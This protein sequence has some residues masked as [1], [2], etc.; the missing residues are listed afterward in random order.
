MPTVGYLSLGC[1]KNLVDTETFLA[2]LA[3]AG[4]AV[5]DRAEGVDALVINTC[6]FI[7]P[8]AEE[9]V[10]E[11]LDAVEDKK[12]G[13][14]KLLVV[15]G[16]MVELHEQELEKEIPEVDLWL[17]LK[18]IRRLPEELAARFGRPKK[19]GAREPRLLTTPRHFSYL[20][21]AEGC[22]HAC[23]FCTI[24]RIRGPYLSRPIA[25][26]VAE[27]QFLEKRGAKELNL[28]AQDITY[29]GRDRQVSKPALHGRS[30]P[31]LAELLKAL[32]AET[33]V[34]WL[35]LLYGH[36]DHLD[37]KMI[38][39]LATEDRLCRYLDIPLQH[40]STKILRDMGRGM[41]G[42]DT[43]KLIARL[44][45]EI[46]GLA[47]RTTMLVGFPGESEDDFR[48]LLEFVEE[49]RFEHLGAFAFSPQESTPAA[50]LAEPVAAEEAEAR[51]A[52]LLE[53]QREVVEELNQAR[54]GTTETVLVD[55]VL[56][57][58]EFDAVGR[59]RWQAHEVDSVIWL[60]GSLSLGEFET[61]KLTGILEYDIIANRV[62]K[63]GQRTMELDLND[64]NQVSSLDQQLSSYF[65]KLANR[66]YFQ[67]LMLTEAYEA[68]KLRENRGS[69]MSAYFDM[70]LNYLFVIF[71][72]YKIGAIWNNNFPKGKLEG[73]SVLDSNE[74]FEGKMEILRHQ[75]SF[76]LRYRALWDKIMGYLILFYVPDRYDQF[77]H[78]N[79]KLRSFN[80]I[81]MDIPEMS[82][83]VSVIA[84]ELNRFNS[85]FR[86]PEAHRTG[87]IRKWT[88]TMEPINQNPQIELFGYSN[89]LNEMIRIINNNIGHNQP[90]K[91]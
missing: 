41:S 22:D 29:Y 38:E 79:S 16:C 37:E 49:A 34:P 76:I 50:A 53:V 33:S 47:L 51:L 83:A 9:S 17:S 19:S 56:K 11:I 5:T 71:D 85:D 84:D 78:A 1:F 67:P 46:P 70:K 55:E 10:D 89:G 3:A 15:V 39:L 72:I 12:A 23:A 18:E 74:K 64:L 87:R 27:A 13:K 77:D 63:R 80:K 45:R 21:I 4:F 54:I 6:G 73:G 43:R 88:L 2:E 65:N 75:S 35:R 40:I 86:T 61:V 48:E 66:F 59:A 26:I 69:I 8:A 28:L 31:S 7:D 42:E 20:K 91:S 60:K 14:V 82:A 90:P 44:R 52:D 32:L 57:D 58:E 30:T 68:F 81:A 36:P 24:P 62:E 25:E